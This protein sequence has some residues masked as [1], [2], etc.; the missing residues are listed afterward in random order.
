MAFTVRILLKNL[1]RHIASYA[2]LYVDPL[3]YVECGEL[4]LRPAL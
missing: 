3:I 4:F 1:E 2:A